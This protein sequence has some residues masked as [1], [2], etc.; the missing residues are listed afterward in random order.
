MRSLWLSV[1]LGSCASTDA[2]VGGRPTRSVNATKNRLALGLRLLDLKGHSDLT[3]GFFTARHPTDDTR[4][5]T[6]EHGR[7]G[8]H[9]NRVRVLC[10]VG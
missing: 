7:C 8:R 10:G 3:A 2:W 6:H 4:F 1:I 5:L 9:A